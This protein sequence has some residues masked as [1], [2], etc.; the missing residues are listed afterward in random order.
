MGKGAVDEQENRGDGQHAARC[1]NDEGTDVR[2]SYYET[3]DGGNK[4]PNNQDEENESSMA[5][6]LPRQG[7]VKNTRRKRGASIWM[8]TL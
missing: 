7:E 1:E 5:I 6:Q 2:D 4:R 8:K 3:E